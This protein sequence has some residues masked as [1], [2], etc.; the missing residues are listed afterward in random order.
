MS[1]A[2]AVPVATRMRAAV[3]AAMARFEVR[4]AFDAVDVNGVFGS[5]GA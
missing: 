2:V 5:I 3:S 1:I 4:G